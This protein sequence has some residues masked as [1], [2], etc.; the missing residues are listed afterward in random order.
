MTNFRRVSPDCVQ[1]MAYGTN[2]VNREIQP[3]LQGGCQCG[4]EASQSLFRQ[5]LGWQV[6]GKPLQMMADTKQNHLAFMQASESG[7]LHEAI[8]LGHDLMRSHTQSF[9]G[10]ILPPRLARSTHVL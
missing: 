1:C 9:A 4:C 3:L 6:K 5:L 10:D 7:W 2:I 8:Q